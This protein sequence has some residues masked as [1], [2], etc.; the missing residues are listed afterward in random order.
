MPIDRTYRATWRIASRIERYSIWR[1]NEYEG[2]IH[3]TVVGVHIDSCIA[4]MKCYNACPTNVFATLSSNMPDIVTPANENDC[5][6]CMVCE[7]VCPTDAI[8]VDK[9]V[10]SDATLDSLLG[11]V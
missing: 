2:E 4:C 5:I 3:G 6:F 9:H 10:G 7:L 11:N 8:S 1:S